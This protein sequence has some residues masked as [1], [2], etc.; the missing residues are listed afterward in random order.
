MSA[1]CDIF[2]ACS[3]V[4][5]FKVVRA[6]LDN[7]KKDSYD[8]FCGE[9]SDSDCERRGFR[10]YGRSFRASDDLACRGGPCCQTHPHKKEVKRF[11]WATGFRKSVRNDEPPHS[12]VGVVVE[13]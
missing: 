10:R 8:V 11:S 12:M 9:T 5:P 7:L 2:E 1:G 3:F 13:K 6:I 4:Y